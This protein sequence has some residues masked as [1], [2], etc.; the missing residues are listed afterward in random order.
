M[1]LKE[2]EKELRLETGLVGYREK[3]WHPSAGK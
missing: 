3:D 1:L 2:E